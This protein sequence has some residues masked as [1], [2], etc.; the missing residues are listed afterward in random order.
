MQNYSQGIESLRG[1]FFSAENSRELPST[2]FRKSAALTT[3]G[4]GSA[5]RRGVSKPSESLRFQVSRSA[6][7]R[8]L[9]ADIF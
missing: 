5:C 7:T 8:L 1:C 4:T 9:C 2:L 3:S 6:Q